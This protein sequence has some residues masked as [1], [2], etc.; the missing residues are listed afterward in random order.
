MAVCSVKEGSEKN[1][2]G[3]PERQQLRK[4]S[5]IQALSSGYKREHKR[6][7]MSKKS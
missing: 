4:V 2:A 7:Q 3:G 5:S 6:R 1:M